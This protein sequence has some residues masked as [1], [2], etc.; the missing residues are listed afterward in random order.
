M[1]EGKAKKVF[2]LSEEPEFLI[3]EFKNSA[4]AFNGKKKD[5]IEG[6]AVTNTKISSLLLSYL[7]A[8]E[9]P[10]HFVSQLGDKRQKIR[11]LQMIPLEV[12]VRNRV[13]GSLAKRIS[14]KEGEVLS[15]FLIEFFYKDD[16]SQDPQLSEEDIFEK[17]LC[18]KKQLEEIKQ[19]ASAINQHLIKLFEAVKIS[20]VDFKLEFGVDSD[21]K[22]RLGDEISPDTCRLWDEDSGTKFD[23]DRFRFDLG[24]LMEGYSEVRKRL[25]AALKGVNQ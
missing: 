16:A 23:K 1:Y 19:L 25:E 7:E 6:K 13:A 21:S 10:T 15:P 3:Q 20:L 2:R 18:D 12:V 4:T 11:K 22:L 17:D 14:K 24:D 5:E 8:K 9:I